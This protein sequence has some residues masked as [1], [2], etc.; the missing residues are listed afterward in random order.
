MTSRSDTPDTRGTVTRHCWTVSTLGVVVW[1][2][3]HMVE[4]AVRDVS[5]YASIMMC[6]KSFRT[7]VSQ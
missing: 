7:A 5:G 3:C 6:V 1:N 4:P 2:G